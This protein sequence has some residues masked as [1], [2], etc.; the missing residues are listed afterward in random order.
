MVIVLRLQK[1][2]GCLRL[3]DN[4]EVRTRPFIHVAFPTGL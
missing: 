2:A 3:P 1:L 4:V